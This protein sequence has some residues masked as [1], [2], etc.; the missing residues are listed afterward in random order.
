MAYTV[1]GHGL[2]AWWLLPESWLSALLPGLPDSEMGIEMFFLSGIMIVVGAVWAVMY[3][4]DLLLTG[5][6]ATLGRVKSLPPLLRTALSYPMRNRFRTGMTLAMFSLVVFTL[7]VMSFILTAIG[8]VFDD[9]E[10]L[11]G[12]FDIR[13]TVSASNPIR[14][15]EAAIADSPELS[16]LGFGAVGSIAPAAVE[17]RAGGTDQPFVD[18]ILQGA[19]TGFTESVTYGFS[20]RA[21][22][23]GSA[24]EV[25]QALRGEPRTVV[26]GAMLVPARTSFSVGGFEPPFLFEG[27]VLEDEVLP[28]VTLE[29][30]DPIT[31]EISELRVIGVFES[32]AFYAGAVM[33]SS[34]TLWALRTEP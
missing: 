8:S 3:N 26:V 19:D 23:Y 13:T 32:F 9:T 7:V 4:S 22:E 18:F 17:A 5:L 24:D 20:M 14:D 16:T 6:I 2:V 27:F 31:G 34:E 10:R 29:V 33:T 25:W 28:E 21:P 15:L 30:G 12:G 11:S 1:A